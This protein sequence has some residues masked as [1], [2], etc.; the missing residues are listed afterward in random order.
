MRHLK[1]YIVLLVAIVFLASCS[2]QKAPINGWHKKDHWWAP[3]NW[4]TRNKPAA[5]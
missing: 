5:F 1:S 2:S 3:S 4:H